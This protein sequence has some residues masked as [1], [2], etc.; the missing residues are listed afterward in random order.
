MIFI[1]NGHKFPILQKNNLSANQI[2]GEGL[3]ALVENSQKFPAL[4]GL[5]F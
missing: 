1:E 4:E 2:S 5:E 3:K